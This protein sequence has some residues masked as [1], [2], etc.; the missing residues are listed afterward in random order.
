MCWWHLS[1]VSVWRGSMQI[2][3][4]PLRLAACA[5]VQKCR[6]DAIELLP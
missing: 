4:A 6:F 5:K 3:F 1:A 2:S